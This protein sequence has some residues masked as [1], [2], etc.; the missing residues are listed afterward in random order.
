MKIAILGWGSLIWRPGTLPMATVWKKGGPVLPLE[1]SRISRSRGGALTVVIDPA[2]GTQLP[3]RFATSPRPDIRTAI[4]DLRGR[5]HT[6]QESIGYVDLERRSQHCQT[7]PDAAQGIGLWGIRN[8]FD[9]V[10]W[11]D[12]PGNYA[13][14]RGDT[15]SVSEAIRY[16][17]GLKEPS[18]GMAREYFLRAPL[19]IVTP[20]RERLWVH[21]WL[22]S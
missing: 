19:E 1:F 3:T 6:E 2:H 17:T 15:F 8:G 21:P 7:H 14:R 20:L 12:L 4:E 11:T 16:L 5:E 9:A 10:I 22:W 13:E 18:A